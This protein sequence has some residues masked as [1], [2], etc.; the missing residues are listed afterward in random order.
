MDTFTNAT[1]TEEMMC[2]ALYLASTVRLTTSP[3]PWVGAVILDHQGHVVGT[4]ATEPPGGR[5][6]EIVALAEAGSNAKG[7]TAIVTL[8]PC[9]HHGRTPP[10]TDALIAAG[11]TRV[12]VGIED[13]DPRVAGTGFEV[14]RSAGITVDVGCRADEITEQLRPYIHHRQTGRPLVVLKTASTLDGKTSAAD[15]SSRWITSDAART[16]VHQLRAESNAVL[17]GAGTVRADDPELT[18]RHV[19]GPDP[20]RV[21]LGHAPRD[22][23]V[24]PCLEWE[25]TPEALL[26]ELGTRGC[27]QLLVEGG[28]T[29]ARSLLDANLVDRWELHLAPALMGG[30]D[31][32]PV[33]AGPTAP[34]IAEIRRGRIR[35]VEMIGSDVR[36]VIDDLGRTTAHPELED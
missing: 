18:V 16:R 3:N 29:V 26:D 19:S 11:I 9:S 33:I 10:C 5:H 13:P 28:A 24:H 20:L 17:V 8:E 25:G 22:A 4:G 27:L 30:S 32:S 34:T 7:G 12:I 1:T 14:L 15:G 21:V 6:A 35:E 36:I 23:R 31:G 2:F